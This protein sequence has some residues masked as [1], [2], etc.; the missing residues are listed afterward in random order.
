MISFS[1]SEEQKMVVN[2]VKQFATD[3]MRK[4]FR[5]CDEAG[6]ITA[7]IVDTAWELGLAVSCIPEEHGGAVWAYSAVTGALLAGEPV[8]RY[9]CFV[10]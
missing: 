10:F 5:E 7:E 4:K 6:E 8:R 3:V 9:D 2:T 1:P